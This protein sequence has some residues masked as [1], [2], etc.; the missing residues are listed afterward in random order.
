MAV[1]MFI[2]I[3]FSSLVMKMATFL[4]SFGTEIINR[5]V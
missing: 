5:F 4:I 3:L 1:I 2:V